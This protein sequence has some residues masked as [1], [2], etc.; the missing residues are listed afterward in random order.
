MASRLQFRSSY[1]PA[2]VVTRANI[3]AGLFRSSPPETSDGSCS[4]MAI[5][6]VFRT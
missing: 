3:R 4:S 5:D 6:T 2:L 1:L